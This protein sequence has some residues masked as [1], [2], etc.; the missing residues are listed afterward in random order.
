[1]NSNHNKSN[2]PEMLAGYADGE[3]SAADRLTVEAWL[4]ADAA[5]QTELETQQRLSHKNVE[6]WTKVAPPMPSD[7]VWS[8]VLSSIDAGVQPAMPSVNYRT[9][10][11]RG[12]NRWAV[13]VAAVAAMFL[14]AIGYNFFPNT[15]HN[16]NGLYSAN[17]VFQIARADQIDILSVQGD[18]DM[19]VVGR[20]P[21][22]GPM[23]LVTVGD[24]ELWATA[25]EPTDTPSKPLVAP[26]DTKRPIWWNPADKV[27][28]V[29]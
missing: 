23:D 26:G 24:T 12:R 1:M 18:D 3:L 22:A 7:A 5:A 25:S 21:L 4:A 19:I 29:P 6:L 10:G 28:P 9:S 2:R 13:A 16:I 15:S 27:T 14:I 11:P 20:P 8:R 17:D